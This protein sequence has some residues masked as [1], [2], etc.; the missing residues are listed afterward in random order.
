MGTVS[1]ILEK[2][3][4]E[5]KL[6]KLDRSKLEEE[7]EMFKIRTNEMAVVEQKNEVALF[8]VLVVVL[9]LVVWKWNLFVLSCFCHV[10][11]GDGK[12]GQIIVSVGR[13]CFG[14]AQEGTEC[15][16]RS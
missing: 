14:E 6:M 12:K 15:S 16:S 8:L 9:L 10:V 1:R 11:L 13:Y 2:H 5:L 4:K 3:E 7:L